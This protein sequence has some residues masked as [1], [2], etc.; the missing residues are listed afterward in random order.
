MIKLKLPVSEAVD[1]FRALGGIGG[2]ASVD[3]AWAI[4]DIKDSLEKHNKRFDEERLK[5]LEKYGEKNSLQSYTVKKDKVEA[6]TEEFKTL[7]EVE[8]EVEFEPLDYDIVM[9]QNIQIPVA[10]SKI[11]RK[12]IV[13]QKIEKAPV[14]E[15]TDKKLRKIQAHK[16]PEPVETA[17][18]PEVIST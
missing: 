2:N 8:V 1:A 17:T 5:L 3:M 10:A 12:F 9:A 16:A 13:K 18:K 14:V 15:K 11:M 6:F 4:D 7:G